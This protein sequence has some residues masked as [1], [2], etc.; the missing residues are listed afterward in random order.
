[1]METVAKNPKISN[2]EV[3]F[4]PNYSF[5]NNMQGKDLCHSTKTKLFL[6]TPK[7]V[8][9]CSQLYLIETKTDDT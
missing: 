4:P 8:S 1:M 6:P 9:M 7:Y 2:R 3:N 5:S